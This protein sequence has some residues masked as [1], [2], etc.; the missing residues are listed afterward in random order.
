MKNVTA[1]QILPA[2]YGHN[3]IVLSMQEG[4]DLYLVTNN[5][6]LTDRIKGAEEGDEDAADARI[7]AI[8]SVLDANGIEYSSVK[9][10]ESSRLGTTWD[11]L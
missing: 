2:G 11:I 9:A 10:H 4:S 5:T 8:E 7:Q 3:K 1:I 6:R